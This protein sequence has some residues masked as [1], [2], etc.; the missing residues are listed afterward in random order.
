MLIVD[1]DV[2]VDDDDDDSDDDDG[3]TLTIVAFDGILDYSRGDLFT[4]RNPTFV[5]VALKWLNH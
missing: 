4:S 1:D 5:I 2:V 3:S